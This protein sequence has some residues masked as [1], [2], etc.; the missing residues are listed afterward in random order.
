M[1]HIIDMFVFGLGAPV[2]RDVCFFGAQLEQFPSC[3][4]QLFS[5][6]PVCHHAFLH[7]LPSNVWSSGK[8]DAHAWYLWW[9]TPYT[10]KINKNCSWFF[11]TAIIKGWDLKDEEAF[12]KT[13]QAYV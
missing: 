2:Q 9:N 13:S 11:N 5:V 1:R 12:L 3:C 4:G 10:L 7:C 6:A 8:L